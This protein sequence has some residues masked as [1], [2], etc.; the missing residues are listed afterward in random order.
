MSYRILYCI[1]AFLFL[2]SSCSKKPSE[3]AIA[4]KGIIVTI[5]PQH[6]LIDKL[7][8]SALPVKV[9]VPSG[10]DMHTFE[11]APEQMANLMHARIWFKIGDGIE[12]KIERPLEKLADGPRIASSQEGIALISMASHHHHDHSHQH[13]A[14]C[15]SGDKD[16]HTWLS[17][18]LLISHAENIKKQLIEF[19]PEKKDLLDANFEQLKSELHAVDAT[20]RGRLQG[21]PKAILVSHPALTYFCKDYGLEQVSIEY[22]GKE[23]NPQDLTKILAQS[24]EK[25][26]GLVFLEKSSSNKGAFLVAQQLAAKTVE[27]DPHGYDVIEQLLKITD[28]IASQ[29]KI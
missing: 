7:T 10:V 22:E 9:L 11:P 20:I 8:N 6:Y 28:A 13:G 2:G 21:A 12:K 14:K 16:I 19:Y 4:D 23:P 5:A 15:C 24:R 1:I 3:N 18:L 27:I 17:P 25:N 29:P 26:I